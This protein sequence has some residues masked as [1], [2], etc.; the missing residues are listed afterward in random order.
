M[1]I[2]KSY[3][4]TT[5]MALGVTLLALYQLKI[6]E[7]EKIS[8]VSLEQNSKTKTSD[9]NFQASSKAESALSNNQDNNLT[10][11]VNYSPSKLNFEKIETPLKLIKEINEKVFLS[12]DEKKIREQMINDKELIQSLGLLLRSPE[13]SN[14]EDHF[15]A[16]D[17]LLE[18]YESGDREASW[19]EI[20]SVVRDPQIENGSISM[21]QFE[22]LAGNKGELMYEL[23]ALAPGAEELITKNLPGPVSQKIWENVKVKQIENLTISNREKLEFES[24]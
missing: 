14:N 15:A 5:I 24:R 10:Q 23:S 12:D 11:N 7:K 4:I 16:V 18:A 8:E 20:V 19:Q 22:I 6:N 1:K 13:H 9:V 21:E 2:K 17:L 3:K